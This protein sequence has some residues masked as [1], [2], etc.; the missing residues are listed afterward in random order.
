MNYVDAIKK[1]AKR[2]DA[3]F[4]TSEL[5][6]HN[7][8]KGVFREYIIKNCIRPFLPDA[9]GLSSGECF[10][11]SGS[12]SKQLDV[13]V[14]DKLYSYIVPYTEDFIQFPFESVY[15][16]IEVKSN[17]TG[18]ELHTAIENIKSLKKL[19]REKPSGAQIIP[20]RS[21]DIEGIKWS[22]SGTSEPFG[23]IFA[24]R[25]LKP[26]TIIE[27]LRKINSDEMQ[28]LPNMIVLY[29]EKTIIVR[30]KYSLNHTTGKEGL[31]PNFYGDYDGFMSLPCGEDTL[32]IFI[33]NI[34]IHS[35]HERLTSMNMEDLINPII[36]KA[37][38]N[39]P[40][41]KVARYK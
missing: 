32:P 8:S 30:I 17:L 6:K 41:Q 36:D 26:N 15:G 33:T 2:L 23:S 12:V 22:E 3:E 40:P 27:Y 39:M 28:F 38:R 21:I 1:T 29:E 5:I 19:V 10:D 31:Y 11:M 9:Y 24:Y 4:E 35:S 18:D 14:Y 25:S 13:V 7:P 37:L 34:L 16:N 20:N